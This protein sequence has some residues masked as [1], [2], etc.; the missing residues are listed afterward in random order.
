MIMM[1]VRKMSLVLELVSD[2]Q[3]IDLNTVVPGIV[4]NHG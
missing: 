4:S 2:P 1:A 3:V